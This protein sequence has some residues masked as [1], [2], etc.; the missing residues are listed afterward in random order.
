MKVDR[1]ASFVNFIYPFLLK[2]PQSFPDRSASIDG[3]SWAGRV[4]SLTVWERQDFPR[5]D[6]L[7]YFVRYLNPPDGVPATARFW[8]VT[9]AVRQSRFGLGTD[10]RWS[11]VLP[12]TELPFHLEDAQLT[13]FR[14]GAGF[15]T[16]RSTP[17]SD[18]S[19]DWLDFL[20]Y[21]RFV[22]GQRKVRLH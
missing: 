2:E 1:K 11:L 8:R 4:G 6:L 21:Y 3:A 17:D 10:A 22:R 16:I 12:H 9:G 14:V 5:D 20:H 13:L 7:A 15:L 19:D 18:S